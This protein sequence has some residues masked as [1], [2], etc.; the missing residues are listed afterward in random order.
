MSDFKHCCS[1]DLAPRHEGNIGTGKGASEHVLP[2][3]LVSLA[4]D[5]V[6][7]HPFLEAFLALVF[8]DQHGYPVISDKFTIG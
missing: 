1:V 8:S 7:S 3:H 6:W 5:R 2:H 4:Q